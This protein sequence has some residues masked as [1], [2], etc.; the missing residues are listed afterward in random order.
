MKIHRKPH[1]LS[2]S[3]EV[4]FWKTAGS[5]RQL[6]IGIGG[7]EIGS[8][9]PALISCTNPAKLLTLVFLL[10]LISP[11]TWV[12]W[13]G[14]YFTPFLGWVRLHLHNTESKQEEAVRD[15][16]WCFVPPK[17]PIL[18]I[19]VVDVKHFK[20]ELKMFCNWVGNVFA[21]PQSWGQNRC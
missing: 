20:K 5:I 16:A 13:Q 15:V 14:S 18:A 12:I 6:S 4:P 8:H 21:S 1:C 17:M 3:S 9:S 10:S 7:Q 19:L 11:K 2:L